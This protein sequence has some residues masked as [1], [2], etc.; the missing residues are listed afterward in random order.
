[1][2]ETVN[3]LVLFKKTPA[4]LAHHLL[5][6]TLFFINIHL[7]STVPLPTILMAYEDIN[8]AKSFLISVKHEGFSENKINC[9]QLLTVLADLYISVGVSVNEL[10]ARM[11]VTLQ[12]SERRQDRPHD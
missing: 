6:F 7:L 5:T 11:S 10:T 8:L 12:E 2:L 4:S 9:S 3:T 1:M